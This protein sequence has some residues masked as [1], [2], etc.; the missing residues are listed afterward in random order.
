[1]SRKFFLD[2]ASYSVIW[3]SRYLFKFND[4]SSFNFETKHRT[5]V[6]IQIPRRSW[7]HNLPSIEWIENQH[8]VFS[9]CC[10]ERDR[11]FDHRPLRDA[12][13]VPSENNRKRQVREDISFTGSLSL[14][15]LD[16]RTVTPDRSARARVKDASRKFVSNEENGAA[17]SNKFFPVMSRAI[18][19]I[20]FSN[21]DEMGIDSIQPLNAPNRDNIFGYSSMTRCEKRVYRVR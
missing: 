10:F 2:F 20:Y 9:R 21:R 8:R 15:A 17:V 18:P 14:F 19:K 5:N 11:F 7:I 12:Q 16:R 1:M 4:S 13:S 6:K 3:Y